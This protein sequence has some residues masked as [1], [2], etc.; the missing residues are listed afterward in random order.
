MKLLDEEEF[1]MFIKKNYSLVVE[2]GSSSMQEDFAGHCDYCKRDV[3]L[4]IGSRWFDQTYN[5]DT[6]PTFATFF[7]QCPSCKRQSFIQT[8]VFSRFKSVGN[9]GTYV[10]DYYK[11]FQVPTED[12]LFETKDI[13]EEFQILKNTVVEAKFNLANSQYMSATMMFRR[14]LQILAKTVLGAKGKTL[15]NQLEWL[16]ENR[17]NLNI[18]LTQLFHDD[19]DLIRKVGNQSAHPDDDED[20]HEFTKEDANAVHDLFLV[21][22]NE[23]FVLP[24][25]AKIL[26]SELAERRKLQ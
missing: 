11:L 24:K 13:P 2:G 16:K 14:A 15:F 21:L 19:S 6:L 10:Y 9:G 4:K 3:F 17:N 12:I 20:L 1:E 26:K 18:D 22:I 25:K 8:I 23:V 5:D 7:I